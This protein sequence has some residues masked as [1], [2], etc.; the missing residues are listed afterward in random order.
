MT[1]TAMIEIKSPFQKYIVHT[2]EKCVT[3]QLNRAYKEFH[4]VAIDKDLFLGTESYSVA[5]IKFTFVE[6]HMKILGDKIIKTLIRE[7]KVKDV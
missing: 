2:V 5:L 6:E 7:I 4:K 3:D 1:K